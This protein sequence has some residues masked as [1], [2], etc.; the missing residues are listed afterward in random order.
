MV[1]L[2]T[3]LHALGLYNPKGVATAVYIFTCLRTC[4][5]IL[6]IW[7]WFR[8]GA[9]NREMPQELGGGGMMGGG[10]K[11]A[12]GRQGGRGCCC[13]SWASS[14]RKKKKYVTD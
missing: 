10:S 6:E 2:Q 7:V 1:L 12:S 5:Y 11:I 13:E 3:E 4:A 14:D 9:P 8:K